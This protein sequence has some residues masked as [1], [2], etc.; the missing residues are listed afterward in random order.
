MRVVASGTIDGC[1][2][3]CDLLARGRRDVHA[4]S[5]QSVNSM[6][7]A[8]ASV[9]DIGEKFPVLLGKRDVMCLLECIRRRARNYR[10]AHARGTFAHMDLMFSRT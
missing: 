8:R 6:R 1:H 4:C 2:A 3:I 5:P 10:A 7:G 9:T